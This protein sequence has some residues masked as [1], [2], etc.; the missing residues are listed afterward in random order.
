MWNKADIRAVLLSCETSIAPFPCC[1]QNALSSIFSFRKTRWRQLNFSKNRNKQWNQSKNMLRKTQGLCRNI[2]TV[3]QR[4]RPRL[5]FLSSLISTV[6]N[7]K[8]KVSQQ[9]IH[10]QDRPTHTVLNPTA[11]PFYF[12]I[13]LTHVFVSHGKQNFGMAFRA[14]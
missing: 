13:S 1:L 12:I 8:Y 3:F 4:H 11:K 6:H 5:F 10:K 9:I 2:F 7:L 14:S